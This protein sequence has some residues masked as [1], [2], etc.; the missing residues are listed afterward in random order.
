MGWVVNATPRQLY[1]GKQTRYPSYRRLGGPQ[2]QF[3]N[4]QKYKILSICLIILIQPIRV[5]KTYCVEQR[6]SWES[7]SSAASHEI[8]R[9][10][11]NP[12]VHH[13][14]LSWA[15]SIQSMSP[16]PLLEDHFNIFLPSTRGLSKW[17]PT[18][19]FL[20]QK[21]LCYFLV[22]VPIY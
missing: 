1:S 20:H 15:R 5:L 12:R 17:P 6:P 2:G 14:S 11:W 21:N 7:N 13:L 4:T 22:K 18:L 19:R 9:I 16:I 8:P 10:L 3:R